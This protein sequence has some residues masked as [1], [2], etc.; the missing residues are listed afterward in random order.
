MAEFKVRT[1][2]GAPAQGKPRVYFVC[3]PADFDKYFNKICEDI[4]K[5]HDCAIYYTENMSEPLD[6]S[7]ITVDLGRMNLFV[8]PVTFR[9]M[10]DGCRAMGVDI[11]FAKE[12][13]IAILP[14]M[15]E[16]EIDAIYSLPKNFG[17][18][19]YLSPFSSDTTEISYTD[20]LKKYLD[21]VL[22]SD[23]M[24]KRVRAAFDA[25]I[26]LSY[27]KKDR[28]HANELMRIIHNIPGCRDIA[29]WYDEF[30]TP[31]ESFMENISRAMK[32]SRLFTL[33]VTPNLLEDGN[34][35]MNEEYPAAKNAGMDILPT[36]MEKT[37]HDKLRSKFFGIPEPVSAGDDDFKK[38]LLSTI[39]KIAKT[40]NDSEPEHNFL[41]GLA[42]LNGIDVEKNVERG[43]KLITMAANANLPEAMETLYNIYLT[44]AQVEYNIFE[45]QKWAGRLS[46]YYTEKLGQENQITLLWMHNLGYT[47]HMSGKIREPVEIGEKVLEL[48]SRLL[49]EEHPDTLLIINNLALIYRDLGDPKKAYETISKA[50]DIARRTLGEEHHNTLLYLSNLS[51]MLQVG[52][53]FHRAMECSKK[54]YEIRLRV[55]GEEHLSTIESLSDLGQCYLN[56]GDRV[57]ACQIQEKVYALYVKV[58]GE[59][60]IKTALEIDSLA[61]SH[62]HLGNCAKARE[63]AEIGYSAVR[64]NLGE[65]HPITI[66][67]KNTLGVIYY[68]LGSYAKGKAILEDA[69]A[70]HEKSIGVTN[71]L[72]LHILNNLGLCYQKL[73]LITKAIELQE[74]LCEMQR[75]IFGE[76]HPNTL[77][78]MGN[79]AV[80]YGVARKFEDQVRIEKSLYEKRRAILGESHP[81]TILSLYNQAA[82]YS[83]LRKY[84]QAA[85]LLEEVCR[86]RE[87][88]PNETVHDK[89]ESFKLL[90]SVYLVS[91]KWKKAFGVLKKYYL[92]VMSQD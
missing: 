92:L 1:K 34:F 88:N 25:Y 47:Y 89:T 9:L 20:K 11:A 60:N 59:D 40:E 37:D 30:L 69:R 67:Y 68:G 62:Y 39:E 58:F 14:F 50:Y 63:F 24:A 49:G 3:H 28:K 65:N 51:G 29:V 91:F 53:D 61:L 21:A 64:N 22:I 6:E 10:S 32:H 23:E 46:D 78:Y 54:A 76:D 36:E 44:G 17:E 19:Q 71:I 27:R 85:E 13:N 81:N 86:L 33:L 77:L 70:L 82:A 4:F 7:N 5:T 31:G 26:F 43:L 57:T 52:G 80:Y 73:G 15:M 66:N 83:S 45:A 75:N 41:I 42:Y 35:V 55:F 18:R 56:L 12:N 87:N 79:L 84:K 38:A 74:K 8:V 72:Y 16:S 90:A 2:G 48:K